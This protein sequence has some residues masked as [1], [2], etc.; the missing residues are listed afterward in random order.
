[1]KSPT[2]SEV[3]AEWI[4]E[5]SAEE[6]PVSARIAAEDSVI[7]TVALCVAAL[8]TDY[9]RAVRE[10]FGASG[11]CS[12]WGLREGADPFGAAAING[13]CAHG[14]DFD[15]TFEGCPVH[16]GAVV[17]PALFAAG[18][19]LGLSKSS[20]AKGL[21][22]GIEIANRLGVVAGKGVHS[23]G[24]H[25]T[26]VLG[27]IG[28]TA[29]VAAA[30]GQTPS[31]IRDSL[32]I[33][34]SMSAGIIEYLADG[35]WTKRMHAGW[36]A[37]SG[38]RAARM[39]KAGFRGPSTVFEG[40][41]G[42]FAAFA[43]SIAPDFTHLT[44]CLGS[45]WQCA[46]IAFKPYACGTMTQPYIDCAS[47]LRDRGVVPEDIVRISCEVGEGTVHRLWEPLPLK[48][49][50]PTPYAAK[51]SSPYAVAI[52]LIHGDAGL[53]R[54]TE[55]ALR[56][57]RVLSLAGKVSYEI[58]PNNEYPRNY[59]GHVKVTLK[60]GRAFEERQEQLRGG[61][62]DPMPRGEILDK[63][64]ANFVFAGKSRECAEELREFAKSL[65]DGDGS[66]SDRSLRT[67]ED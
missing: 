34:G 11:E 15:N 51:F 26:A 49:S 42:L 28:A 47:R 10:A 23:A 20:V 18:Q 64:R 9:G 17:V 27:T 33:A 3:L 38:I 5:L 35:S 32:G 55:E 6:I 43:P 46:R 7:D 36:A 60:N 30:M 19:H 58:D 48:Q 37:Q 41:H 14:E 31:Q 13:T 53:A 52:G 4:A 67:F 21:V 50:P 59:T 61:V 54:F 45:D 44:D 66:F 8:D 1:M 25:P 63:A 2:R 39:G 40:A 22:V 57:S 29:G 24:F 56:D 65:F 62:K 16:S 12:V